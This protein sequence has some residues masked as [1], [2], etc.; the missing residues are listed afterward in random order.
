[1]IQVI[2]KKIKNIID[3][4]ENK[5]QNEVISFKS[6]TKLFITNLFDFNFD[7]FKCYNLS[8]K[9]KLF[10]KIMDFIVCI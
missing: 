3:I 5:K 8:I 9:K 2:C 1:M 10:L 4:N 7:V 6:I